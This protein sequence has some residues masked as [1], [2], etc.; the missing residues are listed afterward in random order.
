MCLLSVGREKS[1]TVSSES[2]NFVVHFQGKWPL[3]KRWD[4]VWTIVFR[5]PWLQKSGAGTEHNQYSAQEQHT[6]AKHR[7]HLQTVPWKAP[8]SARPGNS[9]LNR[10]AGVTGS[11][12][13]VVR[14]VRESSERP[15]QPRSIT[16]VPRSTKALQCH[17]GS[18]V[19]QCSNAL[20]GSTV[21]QWPPGPKGHHSV[22]HVS[23]IP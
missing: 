12:M 20:L 16:K 17:N 15:L 10:L 14:Q 2:N 23:F 7:V 18:L 22:K 13:M 19:L 3:A 11:L 5:G 4:A 9:C 1:Q 21:S 8:T 6:M